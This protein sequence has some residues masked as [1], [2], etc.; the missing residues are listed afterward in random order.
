MAVS[1]LANRAVYGAGPPMVRFAE[2]GHPRYERGAVDE[3][4]EA[5]KRGLK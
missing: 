4:I 1:T 3:W 2:G 5:R